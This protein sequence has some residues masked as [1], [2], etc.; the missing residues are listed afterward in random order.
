MTSMFDSNVRDRRNHTPWAT[1]SLT[2]FMR[3]VAVNTINFEKVTLTCQWR[4]SVASRYW[5]TLQWV[6]AQ[7]EKHE[8]SAQELDHCLWRAAEMELRARKRQEKP[9]SEEEQA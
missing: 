9:E 5:W 2:G 8:A 3:D 6:D 7:G 1:I 4:H